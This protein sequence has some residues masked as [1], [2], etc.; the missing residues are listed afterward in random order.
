MYCY[1]DKKA[2]EELTGFLAD[3]ITNN[4]ANKNEAIL[5]LSQIYYQI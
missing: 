2:I 5:R 3:T 1:R 4:E